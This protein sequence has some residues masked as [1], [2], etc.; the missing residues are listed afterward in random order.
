[1]E[2]RPH[3]KA[4]LAYFATE[5]GGIVTPVSLGFRTVVRFLYD[6]RECIANQTFLETELVFPGD[7]VSADII[8]LEAQEMVEK[9]YKGMDFDLIINSNTIGSG[10]VTDI[11][12]LEDKD[13]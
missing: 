7:T 8:L 10:V 3:F 4:T 5:D 6:S 2:K 13:L 9:I 12:P 11:Y 1:M